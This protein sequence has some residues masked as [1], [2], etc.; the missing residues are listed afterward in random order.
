[1]KQFLFQFLN[2]PVLYQMPMT[3]RNQVHSRNESPAQLVASGDLRRGEIF[4][5]VMK[6]TE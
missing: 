4:V 6:V 1:M 2:I 5:S 3:V